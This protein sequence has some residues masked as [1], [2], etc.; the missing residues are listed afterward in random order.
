[1][2]KQIFID[3]WKFKCYSLWSKLTVNIKKSEYFKVNHDMQKLRK[4][5]LIKKTDNTGLWGHT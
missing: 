4:G 5:E 2:A 3:L 1:M